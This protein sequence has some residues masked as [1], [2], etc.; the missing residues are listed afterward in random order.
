MNARCDVCAVM[1]TEREGTTEIILETKRWRAT[2][3]QNQRFLGKMFV[4]LLRH[5]ATISRLDTSDWRELHDVISRLEQ[6]VTRSFHPSHFNW[7]CLMNAAAM[8]GAPTHAH[9]H[10]HPRYD[11]IAEVAG[12]PFEDTQWYP[13]QD[14]VDHP[15]SDNVYQA[16]ANQI[17]ENL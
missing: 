13:R 4:A 10:L 11:K 2:L 12:E 16:I 17:R 7:S 3:D 15:V 6:A 1:Q 9:W 5:K 8:R 14:K